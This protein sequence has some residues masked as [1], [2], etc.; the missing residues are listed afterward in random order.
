MQL[1]TT[2]CG[3]AAQCHEGSVAEPSEKHSEAVPSG[4][5]PKR[6]RAVQPR[7][8]ATKKRGR[9]GTSKVNE[10]AKAQQLKR[11]QVTARAKAQELAKSKR[12][13]APLSAVRGVYFC[14]HKNWVVSM[15][16]PSTQKPFH[17]GTFKNQREAE[18]KARKLSKELGM[19]I[20]RKLFTA[21][22]HFEP[23]GTQKGI[24]WHR[25][26]WRAWLWVS[27]SKKRIESRFTPD[28]FSAK[29]V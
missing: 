23:L 18:A 10:K 16:N 12:K 24:S 13:K 29:E 25:G 7:N 26:G 28:D 22:R 20:R 5:A 2:P 19:P 4:H 14:K 21:V 17:G 15:Y 9:G 3:S 6:Q 8:P 1:S 11:K 27:E